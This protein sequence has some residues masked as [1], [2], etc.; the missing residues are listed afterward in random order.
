MYI[1]MNGLAS[2][3]D[4]LSGEDN[5]LQ[6]KAMCSL[7]QLSKELKL[8]PCTKR[9]QSSLYFIDDLYCSSYVDDNDVTFLLNDGTR[10][11]G[12]REILSAASQVFAAMLQGHYAERNQS[13]IILNDVSSQAFQILINHLHRIGRTELVS[14][15]DVA[16]TSSAS[17]ACKVRK[18]GQGQT[19][20]TSSE[21][22]KISDKHTESDVAAEASNALSTQPHTSIDVLLE[23]FSLSDRYMLDIL[24][25]LVVHYISVHYLCLDNVVE[26]CEFALTHS[27][28]TLAENCLAYLFS[29]AA[30]VWARVSV[31][32]KVF[33][34]P[35]HSQL[36]LFIR[37]LIKKYINL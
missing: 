32:Q 18:T 29:S 13:E 23:V 10:V 3:Q 22:G 4:A 8:K 28:D 26:I 6:T 15:E 5:T 36:Q 11:E 27:C 33:S 7:L 16:P 12:N 31:L 21:R 19:I 24:K 35:E 30:S 1:T 37:D 14:A 2:L 25:D 34:L 9:D 17:P 20:K